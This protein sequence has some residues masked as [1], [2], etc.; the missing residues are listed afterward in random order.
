MSLFRFSI[1]FERCALGFDIDFLGAKAG[2]SPLSG[3]NAFAFRL[4]RSFA[5]R[6][7]SLTALSNLLAPTSNSFT[8]RRGQRLLCFVN[9][10][11]E[12]FFEYNRF[13]DPQFRG[14][15]PITTSW[16]R[17]GASRTTTLDR[18]P[19][20]TVLGLV[21]GGALRGGNRFVN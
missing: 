18:S 13:R 2:I 3:I 9:Y 21:L 16:G 12:L 11:T 15:H 5:T 4:R 14:F 7:R 19:L 10:L 17:F 1:R 20:V 6:L 8:F